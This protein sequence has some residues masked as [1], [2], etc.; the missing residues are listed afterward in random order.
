[1]FVDGADLD[2][3]RE[4]L[5]VPTTAVFFESPSNPMQEIVDVRGGLRAGARGRR[6][7][8]RRQ[9]LRHPRPAATDGPRRGH[10]R[11]LHHQAHRRTGAHP[12]GCHPRARGVH[13][14]A[15]A[16]PDAPHRALDEPVQRLGADQGPGDLEH[17]GGQG[18]RRPRCG[19]WPSGWNG[20]RRSRPVR[21]PFLD[22]HPQ[23][24]LAEK[25]MAAG[26]T[27]VTLELDGGKSEAFRLLDALQIIDISNNLGDSKSLI[28]HPATTTHRRLGPAGP[29]GD[30]HHRRRRAHLG[31][32]RG[33]GGPAGRPRAGAGCGLRTS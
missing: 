26:G 17:A 22:S 4:A 10:R 18:Q 33:P 21:Y 19:S 23:R 13:P 6:P 5:S 29:A 2:Q 27:V 8:G 1:M 24:A 15:G 9:R 25:Q 14:G 11:L 12:R 20:T 3:W 31:R 28:T 16:E 7:G 30:R 32:A